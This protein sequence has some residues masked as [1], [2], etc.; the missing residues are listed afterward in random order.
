MVEAALK[1]FVY[2]PVLEEVEEE[3]EAVVVLE[4]RISALSSYFRAT[5]L[6][7]IVE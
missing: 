6:S 2:V 7:E 3:G 5:Y 1:I 4:A